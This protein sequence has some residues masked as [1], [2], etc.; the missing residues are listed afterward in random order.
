MLVFAFASQAQEEAKMLRFPTIHGNQVVFSYAGDL[1]TVDINGGVAEKLT[2][3]NE[4]LE[5]FAR[6]S[7]DGKHIAFTGQYDGNTEV[8]VMPAEGGTPKRLTYTATLSRDDVSDRMGP[9]N[10]VMAWKDNENIVFRSRKQ[11]FNDFVGHLFVVNINGGMPEELP[12]VEGSWISYS[13]DGN[14]I[15]FNRVMRE[16]RTWKYYE[17]GMADDVWTFDFKTKELTNLTNNKAQDIFPMMVGEKVYFCS[18]RDRTM[19]LFVYDMNAKTTTKLTDYTNY[20]IKFPSLG[21]ND[22]IYENGG[23]LYRY[24]LKDGKVYPIKVQINND[25]MSRRDK[26]VDASKNINS[27]SI[28]P[29]GQ[30]MA[31]GA[32]GDVWTVPAESGITRNITD[33][34]GVHDRAVAWS[35]KGDYIAYISDRTGEDEIYIQKQDGKEE[36]IQLTTPESISSTYKYNPVWS[37]DAKYILWYDKM[38]RLNMI[39]VDSK[40][41][42]TI[43]QSDAGELR[44][45][46]WSP[47][48]KW[49]AYT[50]SNVNE[51]SRIFIYNIDTKEANPVTDTWFSSSSPVF[52]KNG[53][54]L[55][56][57]SERDFNPDYSWTEWNHSYNN[58]T[59]VYLVTLQKETPSPFITLNNEVKLVSDDAEA[60]APK[61]KKG[62]KAK[63]DD[64]AKKEEDKSI[65]ID[66]DGIIN[67]IIPLPGL[68]AANYYNL[69]GADNALYYVTFSDNNRGLFYY[70]IKEKKAEKIGNVFSFQFTPDGKKMAYRDR[71]SYKIVDAP[72]REMRPSDESLDLSNMKKWV[73]LQ[74]EWAQIYTEAWRQMRDFFYDPNMHGV[75]WNAM[76]DKYAVLVPYAGDRNDI[77]YLI[78]ELIGEL[79]VGH[80]YTGGG[81]RPRDERI[82]MGLLG[83]KMEKDKS[84]YFKINKIL[85]GE[86]WNKATV[87]PLTEVGVNVNEGDYIIAVDGRSTKEMNNIYESL[88]GKANTAVMLTVN[89]KAS[90]NGARDV[91]VRPIDNEY[92]LY[93]YNWVQD[94]I[95]KVTEATDGQVGYVHIPDMGV[96]GLNEFVKYFYPQLNKKAL[97][98]DDR[99]NGGGNVSPM[100]IERLRREIAMYNVGR[101]EGVSTKPAQMM[102]GPKV[103]LLNKYSASDGDLFPWQFKHYKLGKTIGTRSWGG[104]VGIRGSLPFIDGG[105]LNRPEFAPFDKNGNWIIEGYGV[106]P[107]IVIDNNPYLE[108]MGE[109]QQL[110]KAIEVILEEM[111]NWETVPEVPVYPDKSK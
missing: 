43:A 73:N 70:D 81:D 83:A 29:D 90:E 2:N 93:Y 27:S 105:S 9:N 102:N 28:S 21:D 23:E 1:Y 85:K 36:A 17:G 47:D 55:Y 97:I 61:D 88:I 110:N 56:F 86:S 33:S 37:P 46:S 72:K 63:K 89:D 20:D 5:I 106:D 54:Y 59:R 94:N 42:T 19:N 24:N 111:K 99:G 35:P 6:L 41:V 82:K 104:V 30:R 77:N 26:Y 92:Y 65:K 51:N 18:D 62:G 95:N 58:M 49:V 14:K 84:G 109:D 8:Y 15:A 108:Y 60:E 78:G 4:G 12:F 38:N 40:K 74:D 44:N 87:S 52:D 75:D 69:Y 67:R 66:F 79:N 22:I 13:P 34:D 103:L 39:E 53:K 71:S 107:D 3:D 16:F 32:R 10:I 57:T 25:L 7:P 100:I 50:F 96:E 91:I 45:Y 101:N 68:H 11:T 64:K 76:H 31:F 80:A 98:I 48:S